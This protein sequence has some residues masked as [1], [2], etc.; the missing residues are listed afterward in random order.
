MITSRVIDL[1]EGIAEGGASMI[2]LG[3]I[4]FMREDPALPFLFGGIWDD[5]HIPG[6]TELTTAVHK[7]DCHILC[8]LHHPGP[9]PISPTDVSHRL[10]HTDP[11]ADPA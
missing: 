5:K 3:A 9:A 6:M 8:Q 10:D 11:R 1:Y 4:L 7:H 2:V